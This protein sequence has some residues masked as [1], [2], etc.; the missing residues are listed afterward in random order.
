M[1][2]RGSRSALIEGRL[3]SS[4][5]RSELAKLATRLM[6]EAETR[7]AL[8]LDYDERGAGEGRGYRN[9]HRTGRLKTAEGEIAFSAPQVSGRDE[10]FPSGIRAHAKGRTEA[11]D[12]EP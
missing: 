1:R 9:G 5:G 6:L 8:G 2:A 4:D 7:D 11:L 12:G 3:P 10:P